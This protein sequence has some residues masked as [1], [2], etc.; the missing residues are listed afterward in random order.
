MEKTRVLFVTIS[1]MPGVQE[2]LSSN[3]EAF[4]NLAG[5]APAISKSYYFDPFYH[6]KTGFSP[7]V[8]IKKVADTLSRRFRYEGD[9]IKY[10]MKIKRQVEKRETFSTIVISLWKLSAI[11]EQTLLTDTF[12][13]IIMCL[14][15]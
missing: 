10:S 8:A 13:T 5:I 14:T 12:A 4:P 7:S 15:F 1:T 2:S 9:V 6:S 3:H 11:C